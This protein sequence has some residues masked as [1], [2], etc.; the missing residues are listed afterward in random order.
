VFLGEPVTE[1]ACRIRNHLLK[2]AFDGYNGLSESLKETGLEL[3]TNIGLLNLERAKLVVEV[4]CNRESLSL[5]KRG[6]GAAIGRLKWLAE[7]AQVLKFLLDRK[8]GDFETPAAYGLQHSPRSDRFVAAFCKWYAA[9]HNLTPSEPT[10]WACWNN[11]LFKPI[12]E[13]MDFASQ[14]DPYDTGW[15]GQR[16]EYGSKPPPQNRV[17]AKC[18]STNALLDLGLL[19]PLF[20]TRN[21]IILL[22]ENYPTDD[23]TLLKSIL[24][25]EALHAIEY[26][27]EVTL[28]RRGT[29]N[30]VGRVE[31]WKFLDEN[32]TL[33]LETL[34]LECPAAE[35]DKNIVQYFK[36]H[37]EL[38]DY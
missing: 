29:R 19:K 13:Y 17:A 34:D 38:E 25:H 35:I 15:R 24:V 7:R 11:G 28:I 4:T 14:V 9:K 21:L 27:N 5:I 23:S 31:L 20:K 8:I 18:W 1:W 32:P 33:A 16:A 12:R 36:K 26:E 30:E 10:V 22:C 6:T 37:P 2:S 3:N